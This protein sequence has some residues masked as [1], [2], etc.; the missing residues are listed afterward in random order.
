M[1]SESHLFPIILEHLLIC[2][3][4]PCAT[5]ECGKRRQGIPF[6][7]IETKPQEVLKAHVILRSIH[8]ISTFYSTYKCTYTI[9]PSVIF[10]RTAESGTR[11]ENFQQGWGSFL[12][13]L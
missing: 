10:C 6:P 13:F 12:N 4:S 8:S 11:A 9:G 2:Y 1:A 7:T 3:F 5:S